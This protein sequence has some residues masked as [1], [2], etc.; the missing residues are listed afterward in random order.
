MI[1]LA[2]TL[3]PMADFPAAMAEDINIVQADTTQKSL[4]KMYEDGEL[5]GGGAKIDDTTQSSDTTYSSDKIMTKIAEI[6]NDDEIES[7]NTTY[8]AKKINS[9]ITSLISADE[10]IQDTVGDITSLSTTDKS[11][12]VAAINEVNDSLVDLDTK[13][14]D[15]ADK[16]EIPKI[17]DTTASTTSLFSSNKVNDLLKN[18]VAKEARA[19]EK[20]PT[21]TSESFYI[22]VTKEFTVDGVKIPVY[23]K[24]IFSALSDGF[25]ILIDSDGYVYH[26]F[27]NV[28]NWIC[29]T[30]RSEWVTLSSMFSLELRQA[31]QTSWNATENYN[32]CYGASGA[33]T[34]ASWFIQKKP[35]T[36]D[37]YGFIS[38]G[39][40]N[41]QLRHKGGGW[42][43]KKIE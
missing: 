8:S 16:T 26:C 22:S 1:K 3:K 11:S 38:S 23:S 34:E 6:I 30:N 12:A 13:V 20:L 35:D 2:D 27:R 25:A 36:S 42:E 19:I 18:Y 17:N 4:Q 10:E 43:V 15:K 39:I 14:D 33:G 5:G 32:L 41:Y 28:Q 31:F 40:C 24:G 9:E 21:E 37:V 29:R 7:E